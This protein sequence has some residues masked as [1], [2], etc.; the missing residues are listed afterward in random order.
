MQTAAQTNH[1]YIQLHKPQ[2]NT[3]QATINIGHDREIKKMPSC[4]AGVTST[5]VQSCQHE[6]EG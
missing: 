6:N 2:G 4:Y 1:S 5:N 3:R